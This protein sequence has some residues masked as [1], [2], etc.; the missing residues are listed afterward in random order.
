MHNSCKIHNRR[1]ATS[2]GAK[3]VDHCLRK[4]ITSP[5]LY[6][7]QTKLDVKAE[8]EKY[9]EK[10]FYDLCTINLN[11]CNTY[12]DMRSIANERYGLSLADSYLPDGSLNQPVDFMDVL[13]NLNCECIF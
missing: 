5:P 1:L 13:R 12:T 3:G 9:L 4:L 2:T 11:D 10:Q 7:C 8:V 6:V